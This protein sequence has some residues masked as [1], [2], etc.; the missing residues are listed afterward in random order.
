MA[1]SRFSFILA[2]CVTAILA[3]PLQIVSAVERFVAFAFTTLTTSAAA[4]RLL[5][6]SAGPLP[7]AA[8]ERNDPA[9]LNSLRHEA[10]MRRLP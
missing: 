2:A 1:R 10:G 8:F 4:P 5:L 6:N 9:I 7:A 3:V